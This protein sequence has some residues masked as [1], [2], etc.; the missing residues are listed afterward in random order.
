M[1]RFN[2]RVSLLRKHFGKWWVAFG[3]KEKVV[4]VARQVFGEIVKGDIV[5]KTVE[6][7]L[8]VIKIEDIVHVAGKA[9]YAFELYGEDYVTSVE[10]WKKTEIAV[11]P[12]RQVKE[13]SPDV[14]WKGMW[15]LTESSLFYP[16]DPDKILYHQVGSKF[17]GRA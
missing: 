8:V 12:L 17:G 4:D 3:V 5:S 9:S 10:G 1:L 11:L 6:D 2:K 7:R 16:V 15:R 14:K 13:N